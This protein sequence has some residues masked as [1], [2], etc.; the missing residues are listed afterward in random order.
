M[1]QSAII[2]TKSVNNEN[3]TQNP[4]DD[5]A[6]STSIFSPSSVLSPNNHSSPLSCSS[7]DTPVILT[8]SLELTN[9]VPEQHIH[10]D[11][12]H[13]SVEDSLSVCIFSIIQ[14]LN[15]QYNFMQ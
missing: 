6:S 15:I 13:K 1:I 10:I 8:S 3:S 12:D 9:H 7:H 2:V 14:N 11:I 4:V 5:K